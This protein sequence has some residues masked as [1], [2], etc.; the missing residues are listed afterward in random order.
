MIKVTIQDKF[1]TSTIENHEKED[2]TGIELLE[3]V[4]IPRMLAKGYRYNYLKRIL[5]GSEVGEVF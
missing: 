2:P 5:D 1:N 3:K 4:I